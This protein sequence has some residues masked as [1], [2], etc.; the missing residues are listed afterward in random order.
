M[1]KLNPQKLK[2]IVIDGE[3]VLVPPDASIRDMVPSDVNAVTVYDGA[4]KSQ[5]LA[6]SEFDRPLPTGFT[7]HLTH[8]AKGGPPLAVQRARRGNACA[9]DRAVDSCPEAY[10]VGRYN[11]CVA[12]T[13]V[14]H[15]LTGPWPLRRGKPVGAGHEPVDTPHVR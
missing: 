15:A 10:E 14:A 3:S 7:T 13:F 9:E 4:G 6:R 5:L 8:V 12:W 2:P 11:P 1:A